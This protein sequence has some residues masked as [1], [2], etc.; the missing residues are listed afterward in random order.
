MPSFDTYSDQSATVLKADAAIVEP[1][2]AVS[3]SRM[4]AFSSGDDLSALRD[5]A[6]RLLEGFREACGGG[7]EFNG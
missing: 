6:S 2:E 4:V 7:F 1:I 5:Q 3:P